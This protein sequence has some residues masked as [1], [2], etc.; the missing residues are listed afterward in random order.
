MKTDMKKVMEAAVEAQ[1][2]AAEAQKAAVEHAQHAAQHA[3]EAAKGEAAKAAAK[4]W[5]I[6]A[7]APTIKLER[8]AQLAEVPIK[9]AAPQPPKEVRIE[10]LPFRESSDMTIVPK[11][12]L[13]RLLKLAETLEKKQEQ[14]ELKSGSVGED[15]KKL[16][17]MLNIRIGSAQQTPLVVD[18]HF[19]ALTEQRVISFQREHKLTADGVVGPDTWKALEASEK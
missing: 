19:G 8:R 17:Q 16:Q 11:E 1:R 12:E 4:A 7:Q 18:G 15:V 2:D 10:S 3:V 9:P 14:G 6:R 13:K 5:T